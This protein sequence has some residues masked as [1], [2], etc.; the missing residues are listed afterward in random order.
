MIAG[1]K[2]SGCQRFLN[3]RSSRIQSL[4]RLLFI[5]FIIITSCKYII[6][7]ALNVQIS[8]VT[9]IATSVRPVAF[10]YTP[11]SS[12]LVVSLPVY[13]VQVLLPLVLP[14]L[15]PSLPVFGSGVASVDVSAVFLHHP[16]ILITAAAI[17]AR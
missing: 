7:G 11:V 10:G 8:S 1:G 13:P 14:L 9:P 5:I 2:A 16:A 6:Y 15:L 12:P 17:T 4:N 3:S